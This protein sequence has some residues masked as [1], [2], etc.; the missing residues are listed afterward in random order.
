MNLEKLIN[1]EHAIQF[2]VDTW[3]FSVCFG[4]LP[5]HMPLNVGTCLVYTTSIWVLG[6][7]HASLKICTTSLGIENSTTM[8]DLHCYVT[9]AWWL[10]RTRMLAVIKFEFPYHVINPKFC[11]TSERP[12]MVTFLNWMLM[13]E[14]YM[15]RSII[16]NN[17][18]KDMCNDEIRLCA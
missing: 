8:V 10:P 15:A 6:S 16:N 11:F 5:K 2:H 7:C 12:Y 4:S 18:S 14:R 13:I 17:H 9:N 3:F 1:F